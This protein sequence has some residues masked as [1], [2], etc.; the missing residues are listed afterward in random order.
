L[1]D[2]DIIGDDI[3][4]QAYVENFALKIFENGAKVVA[5]GKATRCVLSVRLGCCCL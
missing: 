5:A 3:A 1:K 2:K 4:A